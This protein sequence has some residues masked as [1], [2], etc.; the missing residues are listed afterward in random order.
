MLAALL[1]AHPEWRPLVWGVYGGA[2]PTYRAK[3]L[4]DGSLVAFAS[5]DTMQCLLQY[6]AL[7]WTGYVP[8]P[9]R[10]TAVMVPINLAWLVWGWPNLFLER[11]R[12]VGS[13]VILLGPYTAGDA[14]TSGIDTPELLAQRSTKS[15][16]GRRSSASS[17]RLS[18]RSKSSAGSTS[19]ACSIRFW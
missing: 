19:G 9:C 8:E 13:E 17:R 12:S 6:L 2:P 18:S 10:G 3:E 15:P 5:R 16:S 14:G 1:T 4:L 7:G 11:M